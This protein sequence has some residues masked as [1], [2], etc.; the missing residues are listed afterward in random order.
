MTLLEQIERRAELKRIIKRSVP[1][2]WTQQEAK[3]ELKQIEADLAETER[4]AETGRRLEALED[5]RGI[6]RDDNRA[7]KR[8]QMISVDSRVYGYVDI[9][10]GATAAEVLGVVEV[11]P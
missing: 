2:G 3:R 9:T 8:F 6:V 5:G 7:G 4:L 10:N 1:D 11:K